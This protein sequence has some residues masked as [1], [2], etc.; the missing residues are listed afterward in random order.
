MP[1]V[2]PRGRG[3][4]HLPRR[5]KP[6]V[7]VP[8]ASSTG[9]YSGSLTPMEAAQIAKG[10]WEHAAEAAEWAEVRKVLEEAEARAPRALPVRET[11]DAEVV[12]TNPAPEDEP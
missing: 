6:L 1:W 10:P 8:G 12:T 7:S 4:Q 9:L 5:V 2:M 3:L 11:V